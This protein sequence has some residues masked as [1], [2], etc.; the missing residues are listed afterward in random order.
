VRGALAPLP[1]PPAARPPAARAFPAGIASRDA[2]HAA[3]H[4]GKAVGIT[5]ALR[6]TPYQV[7][8]WGL[9]PPCPWRGSSRPRNR[10]EPIPTPSLRL[11]PCVLSPAGVPA[12]LAAAAGGVCAP[13][14]VAGAAVQVGA[15]GA[16]G[17]RAP[18]GA[19]PLLCLLRLCCSV[20]P[21]GAAQPPLTPPNPPAQGPAGG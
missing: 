19:A 1:T 6:G 4:V 18:T 21:R 5:L 12:P 17:R 16:G 7:R 13:Q 9:A 10:L 11:P 3:S 15:G 14:G 20:L 2:D 8:H